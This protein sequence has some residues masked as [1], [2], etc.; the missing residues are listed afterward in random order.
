MKT[1]QPLP[2]CDALVKAMASSSVRTYDTVTATHRSIVKQMDDGSA[3]TLWWS[4]THLHD[5]EGGAEDLLQVR[6]VL[7][8]VHPRR[9]RK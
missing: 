5:H 6:A 3:A 8:R 9:L 4:C 1:A 2:Y 7:Q